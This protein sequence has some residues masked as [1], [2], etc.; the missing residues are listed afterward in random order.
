MQTILN[1][2]F[3]PF[4][5]ANV[6]SLTVTS[7]VSTARLVSLQ[8]PEDPTTIQAMHVV[9]ASGT[10]DFWARGEEDVYSHDDGKPI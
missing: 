9:E 4:V 2:Q 6:I 5:A 1:K 7:T 8:A 10:L 3:E